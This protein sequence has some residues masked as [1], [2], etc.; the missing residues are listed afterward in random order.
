MS[1]GKVIAIIV[2]IAVIGGGAY[3]LLSGGKAKIAGNGKNISD[4][5]SNIAKVETFTGTIQEAVAK[6]IPLK[7]TAPRDEATGIEVAA[8]YFKGEKYYGEVTMRG[9]EGYIIMVGNCMWNWEKDAKRG[10]K[11]CFEGNIWEQ[12]AKGS[13]NYTCKP[14]VF[15][16]SIFTPPSDVMFIDADAAGSQN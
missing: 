16:D 4:T 11:M 12:Q 2:I 1:T 15:S 14:A 10:V 7:C 5:I 13:G 3:F 8:G 9:K 6:G